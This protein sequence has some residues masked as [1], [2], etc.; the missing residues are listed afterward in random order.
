MPDDD[1]IFVVKGSGWS[2]VGYQRADISGY[3]AE[4]L[5]IV[6]TL[7]EAAKFESRENA[8]KFANPF[9]GSPGTVSGINLRT[10]KERVGPERADH[11]YEL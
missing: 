9:H 6:Y 3:A 11:I 5:K 8:E 2:G 1:W 7:A 10:C 4:D